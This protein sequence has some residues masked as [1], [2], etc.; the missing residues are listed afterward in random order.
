MCCGGKRGAEHKAGGQQPNPD[1]FNYPATG[2]EARNFAKSFLNALYAAALLDA[3]AT[4]HGPK[5]RVKTSGAGWLE[6][7]QTGRRRAELRSQI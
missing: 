5:G 2:V 1:H 4:A 7:Q 3:T 6:G